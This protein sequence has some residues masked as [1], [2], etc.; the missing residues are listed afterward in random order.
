VLPEAWTLEDRLLNKWRPGDA[1]PNLRLEYRLKRAIRVVTVNPES[2][3]EALQ[4]F[5][6][7]V[8]KIEICRGKEVEQGRVV[9]PWEKNIR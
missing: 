3:Q 2:I 9:E 7:T 1:V 4:K 5:D 8:A 6:E